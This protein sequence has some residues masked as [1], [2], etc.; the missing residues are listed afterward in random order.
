MDMDGTPRPQGSAIDIGAY[1]F[2][3]G[4]SSSSPDGLAPSVPTGLQAVAVSASQINLTWPAT[5]DNVDV[6][7]YKVLMNGSQ[8]GTAS[9]TIYS[10][11]GLT[12]GSTYSFSVAAYDAAENE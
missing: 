1:E 5:T 10:V 2:Q 7:G 8:V 9:G 6:V 3:S 11:S 4:S 12:A